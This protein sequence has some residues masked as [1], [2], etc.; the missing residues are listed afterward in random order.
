M[1]VYR[2]IAMMYARQAVAP[3]S[4]YGVA[5]WLYLLHRANLARWQMPLVLRE[6]EIC[7][8]CGMSHVTYIKTRRALVEGAI[9]GMCRSRGAGRRI[10]GLSSYMGS[11]EG[12]S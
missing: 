10:I 6:S 9:S 12:V 7:G 5:M 11:E 4:A 8:A 3:L 1:D 2:Q